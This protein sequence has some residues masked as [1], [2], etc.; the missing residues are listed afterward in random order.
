MS[1]PKDNEAALRAKM[2]VAFDELMKPTDQLP[3]P[4]QQLDDAGNPVGEPIT[5]WSELRRRRAAEDPIGTALKQAAFYAKQASDL[6]RNREG[7]TN[8]KEERDA[9]KAIV[10]AEIESAAA[11]KHWEAQFKKQG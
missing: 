3:L 2:Q 4:V 5:T 11:V 9:R 7:R 8:A 10:T 1:D 6:L